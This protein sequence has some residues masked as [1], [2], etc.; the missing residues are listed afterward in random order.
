MVASGLWLATGECRVA[1]DSL[2]RVRQLP[3]WHEG[4]VQTLEQFARRMVE[5]IVGPAITPQDDSVLIVLSIMA[6]PDRWI[7]QPVIWLPSTKIR[8][9]LQVPPHKTHLSRRDLDESPFF[10]QRV[11]TIMQNAEKGRVLTP[12]DRQF[13]GVHGRCLALDALLEQT[14]YLVPPATA[15]DEWRPILLPTGYP[16]MTQAALKRTWAQV[17]ETVRTGQLEHVDDVGLRLAR[18]LHNLDREVN[19]QRLTQPAIPE[20]HV[21][22]QLYKGSLG[23]VG[24]RF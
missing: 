13:L 15:R 22:S 20:S 12:L 8:E 1:A 16:D 14:V 17:L 23:V 3:L 4:R 6:K 9:T 11:I 24:Q 5:F 2:Q 18:I 7:D 19:S 21:A 10:R